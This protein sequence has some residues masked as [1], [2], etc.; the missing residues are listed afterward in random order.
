[1]EYVVESISSSEEGEVNDRM[2]TIV[3]QI[4]P[5]AIAFTAPLLITALRGLFSE[6]SGVVNIGL[7]GLMV[8]G[9]FT[10]ALIIHV[11]QPVRYTQG[12]PLCCDPDCIDY[13]LKTVSSAA[14]VRRTF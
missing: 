10:G 7:K 6:R 11:L 2:W 5:Y 13:F 4:F 3:Q 14:G 1:M 8:V 12:F 9:S